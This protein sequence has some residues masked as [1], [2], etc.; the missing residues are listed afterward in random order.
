MALFIKAISFSSFTASSLS[1]SLFFL[2][3]VVDLIKRVVDLIKR[4][5]DLIKRVVDLIQRLVDLI[6]RVVDL[7]KRAWY[8]PKYQATRRAQPL[9]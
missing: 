5:V 8:S 7:I 3:R 4:V 2:K 9:S 6:K 1:L